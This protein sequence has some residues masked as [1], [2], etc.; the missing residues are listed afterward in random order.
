MHPLTP[1]LSELNDNELNDKFRDLSNKLNF[2]HRMGNAQLVQQIQMI[3]EDYQLE[4]SSRQRKAYED[5]MNKG[6]IFDGIIKVKK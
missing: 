2:A 6:G 5:M 4:L 3:L 1:N